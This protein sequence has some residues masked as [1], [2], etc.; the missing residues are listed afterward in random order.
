MRYVFVLIILASCAP[1]FGAEFLIYNKVHWMHKL[2]FGEMKVCRAKYENW[3]ERVAGQYIKGD[4]IEVRPDGFWVGP[5]A[6]GFNKDA[7]RVLSIPG[8]SVK[9]AQNYKQTTLTKKSRFNIPTK[10]IETK[11]NILEVSIT[12]KENIS[13]I[14]NIS[15]IVAVLLLLNIA[16]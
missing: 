15:T 8:L 5:K 4:V 14:P 6:R 11:S 2:T 13:A 3:D 1:V 16:S 10:E 7:F 9:M 12:D